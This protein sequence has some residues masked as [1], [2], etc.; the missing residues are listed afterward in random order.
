VLRSVTLGVALSV[1]AAA[2]AL[3]EPPVPPGTVATHARVKNLENVPVVLAVKMPTGDVL[4]G[5]VQPASLPAGATAQVTFYLPPSG[6]WW[7][8]VN[9]SGMFDAADIREMGSS[10]CTLDMEVSTDGHGGLGCASTKP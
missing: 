1:L 6:D 10:G 8:T 5:A 9:G 2:C 7:I 3:L 4:P